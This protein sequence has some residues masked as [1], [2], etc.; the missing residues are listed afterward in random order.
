MWFVAL[1]PVC[2]NLK[3]FSMLEK[4][5]ID[6]GGALNSITIRCCLWLLIIFFCGVLIMPSHLFFQ[7]LDPGHATPL[8]S[9][10]HDL[11]MIISGSKDHSACIHTMT[12]PHKC[13]KTFTHLADVTDVSPY[14]YLHYYCQHNLKPLSSLV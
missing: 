11:G 13:L 5:L 12:T 14:M 2:K 9:V 4:M 3:M 8:T 7:E 6:M 10:F 1:L